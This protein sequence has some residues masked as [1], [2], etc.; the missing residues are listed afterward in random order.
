MKLDPFFDNKYEFE[1]GIGRGT[2][3]SSDIW[4]MK[5]I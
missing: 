1:F 3:L 2:T 5:L 4:N